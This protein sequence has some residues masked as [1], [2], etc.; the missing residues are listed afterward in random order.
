MSPFLFIP[1]YTVVSFNYAGIKRSAVIF[2]I[3]LRRLEYTFRTNENNRNVEI[4]DQNISQIR[5]R[6]QVSKLQ[7]GKVAEDSK[8]RNKQSNTADNINANCIFADSVGCNFGETI[9]S[10]ML[11]KMS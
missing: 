10:T 8:C 2:L 6:P 3:M 7:S 9:R 11:P 5:E 1:I 4:Y